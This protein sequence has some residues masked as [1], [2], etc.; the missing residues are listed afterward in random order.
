MLIFHGSLGPHVADAVAHMPSVRVLLQVDDDT[1]LIEGAEWYH[2]VVA[3]A[4][5][6]PASSV[7][8]RTR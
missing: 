2:D 8:A 1:A 7:P 4:E 6:A 5:P 3:A